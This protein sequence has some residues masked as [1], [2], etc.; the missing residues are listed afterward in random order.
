M[1]GLPGKEVSVWIDTSP[2]TNYPSLADGKLACDVA[3]IG[4]GITG[5]MTAWFLREAGLDVVVVERSRMVEGTTGNSTAKLTS[6]HELVYDYL[7]T[8]K[9]EDVARAYAMANQ[10]A[11]DT[12]EA[13]SIELGIDCDFS[14]R[15]AFVYTSAKDHI[16]AIEQEV[17][18]ARKIGLPASFETSVDLPFAIE[19]A[20]KFAGQARF[21]PRKFLLGIAR[22]LNRRNVPIFENT[23]VEDILPGSPNVIE[24]R[25]GRIESEYV[26]EA[27]GYPFWKTDIFRDALDLKMSYLLGVRLAKDAD[28]PED[29]YISVD[30]PSRTMRSHPYEEGRILLFGGE[31]YRIGG[32]DYEAH[33]ENL[34]ADVNRKFI[35]EEVVYRWMASDALSADRMPYIGELPGYPHIFVATGYSAWGLAWS[36]AAAGIIS[37]LIVERPNDSAEVFGLGR[38]EKVGIR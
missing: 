15:N 6:Q 32:A 24:T 37:D 13:L 33:Y 36:A 20:V 38:M 2:E 27:T 35:V 3:V 28:Y 5:L 7:S 8:E 16:E 1:N 23:G 17:H 29:M 11:I 31:G 26:V 10:N 21:H 22:E 19:G 30:S 12:I 18:A 9:G 4:A 25:K 14:R 34:I